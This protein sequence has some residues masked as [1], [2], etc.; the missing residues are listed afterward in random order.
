M[1]QM[2]PF[3]PLGATFLNKVFV[4]ELHSAVVSADSNFMTGSKGN[5]DSHPQ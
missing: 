3:S 4:L 1:P 2:L 5:G